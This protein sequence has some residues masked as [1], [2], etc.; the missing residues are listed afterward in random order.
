[1]AVTPIHDPEYIRRRDELIERAARYADAQH[2][3]GPN[4]WDGLNWSARWN[5]AFLDKMDEL[6]A[7]A[8]LKPKVQP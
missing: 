1:M 7:E 5:K 8:G 6:A 4:G 2:G 3:T